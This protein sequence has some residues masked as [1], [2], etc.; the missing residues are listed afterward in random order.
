MPISG[1]PASEPDRGALGDAELGA[2][3]LPGHVVLAHASRQLGA[4]EGL[5][6]DADPRRAERCEHGWKRLDVYARVVKT[7]D[8]IVAVRPDP[9][10]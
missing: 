10:S 7:D 5:L 4:C 9:S 1:V 2:D 8:V 3:L 6:C